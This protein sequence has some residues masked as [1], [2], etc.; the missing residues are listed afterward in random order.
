MIWNPWK[1]LRRE[2]Q[3]YAALERKY[4]EQTARFQ[5]VALR[6]AKQLPQGE[7]RTLIWYLELVKWHRDARRWWM[8]NRRGG[9]Q[10]VAYA[11]KSEELT[12]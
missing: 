6:L 1:Q 2:R 3:Q 5:E 10:G 4:I 8:A 9:K 11:W 7:S 12:Q